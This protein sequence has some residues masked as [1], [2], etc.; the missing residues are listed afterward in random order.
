MIMKYLFSTF[1][2][3]MLFY[4]VVH[5]SVFASLIELLATNDVVVTDK[6]TRTSSHHRPKVIQWDTAPVDDD[7][8]IRKNNAL[9]I[10]AAPRTAKHVLALWSE[11]ECFTSNV[12]H[13]MVS[14]PTWSEPIL[15]QV[16]DMAKASI[17]RLAAVDLQYQT[18][19]NDRYDVGL[20]CDALEWMERTGDLQHLEQISLLNDSVFAL[21]EY[22][23]VLDALAVHNASMTSLSYS[24]I[25]PQG[26]GPDM[27]WVESVWRGF[28]RP[29]IQTFMEYS[30]RPASDPMFCSKRWWGQKGC[31]VENFERN[32]VKQFPRDKV[33]GL[34]SSDVPKEML[35]RKHRFPQWVRH[36][37]YWQKLVEEEGF[38]VSK[39]NW[40][41]MIGSLDDAR[42]QTCTQYLD[43][44]KLADF[45]FS[46]A[47]KA[48]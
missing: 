42:L 24:L 4:S 3:G 10:S 14:G 40:P 2:T 47:V 15:Q 37:P 5:L 27:F 16:L 32:M 45:D 29:G 44:S 23:E 30:C 38:P 12:D 36:P 13:V 48:I 34:F 46:V 11:L 26:N 8:S 19:V 41:E 17:P 31:I 25:R 22:S 28:D 43:R 21:R 9:V 33:V 6:E 39:V 20:W 7:S 18:F 35:S 1:F